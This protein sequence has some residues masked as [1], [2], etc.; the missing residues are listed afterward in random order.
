MSDLN[1]IKKALELYFDT[2]GYYP[3][4]GC[5]W[6]CNAYR[7]SNNSVSWNAL[8]SDLSPYISKLPVDPVNTASCTGPWI[9][10]SEC[11]IY[12]YG[13]VGRNG[14]GANTANVVQYDL[15]ARLEDVSNSQICGIKNWKWYFNNQS[16]C[17]AFGG[18]FNNQIYEASISYFQI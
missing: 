11:Y 14:G 13:N 8:A 9:T 15:T 5:G 12:T 6:D 17:V 2:N 10:T 3:Q 4:S 18:P 1:E 16:W 7:Y